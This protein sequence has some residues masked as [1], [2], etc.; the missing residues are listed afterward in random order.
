MF[1]I[2]A[3]PLP[4]IV[5]FNWSRKGL[6]FRGNKCVAEGMGVLV[7]GVATCLPQ[8][9]ALTGRYAWTLLYLNSVAEYCTVGGVAT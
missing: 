9:Q 7:A 6:E 2:T 4:I 5:G 8:K 1:C 3:R